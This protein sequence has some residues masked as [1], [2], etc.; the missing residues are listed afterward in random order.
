M[1]TTRLAHLQQS[2]LSDL[3]IRSS[4]MV[5]LGRV[6]GLSWGAFGWVVASRLGVVRGGDV[7]G[8]RRRQT[9]MVAS[10]MVVCTPTLQFWVPRLPPQGTAFSMLRAVFV[11]Y[12]TLCYVSQNRRFYKKIRLIC[13]LGFNLFWVV[14]ELLSNCCPGGGGCF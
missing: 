8:V 12:D 7:L 5:V 1:S 2:N 6:D 14:V 10:P 11:Y 3:R 4:R 13:I 9:S